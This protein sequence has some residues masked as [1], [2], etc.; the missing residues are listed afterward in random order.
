MDPLLWKCD[1]CPRGAYCRGPTT[2]NDVRPIKGYWRVP[3]K[4]DQFER[5]P[6]VGDCSGVDPDDPRRR[7]FGSNGTEKNASKTDGCIYGTEGVLC[8]RCTE[9]FNRDANICT[10]CE[11]GSLGIRIAIVIVLFVFLLAVFLAVRK[12]LKKA[13][14]KYRS[15][16]RDVLRIVSIFVTFSQINTSMPSIIEVKWPQFFVDF[17][18]NFNVVNID[19]FSVIGVSCVGN[20]NFYMSFC[21]MLSLPT[22]I[23][24]YVIITLYSSIKS[25]NSTVAKLSKQ[26]KMLKQVEAYHA[27]YHLIDDD[28]GGSVSPSEFCV[29][30]AMLGWEINVDQSEAVILAMNKGNPSRKYRDERGRVCLKEDVFVDHMVSS[31][32]EAMCEKAGGSRRKKEDGVLHNSDEILKWVLKRGIVSR[33]MAGATSLLLLYISFYI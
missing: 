7:I 30:F 33:V 18:S 3:W 12:K 29:L 15:L 28:G 31:K 21:A 9:G 11:E 4:L 16:Y 14:R 5:C 24:L 26:D 6:Y 1:D 17:V 32:L 25:M 22:A 13:W 23:A 10:K 8:S 27:L 19:L 2:W 20:F